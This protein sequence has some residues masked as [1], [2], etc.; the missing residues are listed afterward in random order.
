VKYVVTIREV[1]NQEVEIE[2]SSEEEAFDRVTSGEGVH[3]EGGSSFT[4]NRTL[5]REESTWDIALGE[6]AG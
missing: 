3:L 2:A 1:W 5:D 6:E 4:F